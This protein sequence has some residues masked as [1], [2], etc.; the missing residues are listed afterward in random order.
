[1]MKNLALA[2]GVGPTEISKFLS[3]TDDVA[4]NQLSEDTFSVINDWFHFA[5]LELVK[6]EGFQSDAS[7]IAKRLSI[8]PTQAQ[9][10]VERLERL[11]FIQIS[12]NEISLKSQNNTWANN[13][14]TSA[15]RKNL[16]K[17]LSMKAT[18]AI[19]DIPFADRES[20][21]LT[22]ACS[23]ELLP[24]LKKKIQKFRREIHQFIE[25]HEKPDEVYQLV[26]S[27]YPLS[28]IKL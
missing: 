23:K 17:Q 24:E 25:A 3:S 28:K 16:Q 8:H 7:W 27:F 9:A 15:A 2:I 18:E 21:S 22:I 14:M 12:C 5:I 19:E 6:T 1:M 26:V 20:G 11:D 10:A 13:E 4:Y